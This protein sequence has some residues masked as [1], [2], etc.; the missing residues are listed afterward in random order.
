Y[1]LAAAPVQ[2]C[3]VR[4]LIRPEKIRVLPNGAGPAHS[5][6]SMRCSGRVERLQYLGYRTEY[7]ILVGDSRMLGGRRGEGAQAF[8]RGEAVELEWDRSRMLIFK[9]GTG[10]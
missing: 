7:Q 4:V 3:L 2:A 8:H 10:K 1:S 6:N 5:L 9:A